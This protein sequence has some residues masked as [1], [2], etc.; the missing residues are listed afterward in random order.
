MKQ[1]GAA[2]YM[3]LSLA[4]KVLR[5]WHS[6]E[7][8]T[9]FDLENT[10]DEARESKRPEFHLDSHAI[11]D[12]CWQRYQQRKWDVYLAVFDTGHACRQ[13][14]ELVNGMDISKLIRQRD[15]EMEPEGRTCFAKLPISS[16]GVPNFK[17]LSVSTLP[18]ALGKLLQGELGS[19]CAE[20]FE[21]AVEDLRHQLASSWSCLEEP[22]FTADY[23]QQLVAIVRQWAG[24]PVT[25]TSPAWIDITGKPEKKA[26]SSHEAPPPGKSDTDDA[27]EEN[28]PVP[29]ELPILNSFYFHD[30]VFAQTSLQRQQ[31]PNPLETYLRSEAVPKLDLESPAGEAHIRNSLDPQNFNAGRWPSSPHLLQSL[32]QQF[33]M[34][35][36]LALPIGGI[37]SVNGPPGTGKTTLLRDLI[38]DLIIQR[39]T[40]MSKLHKAADGV[41]HQTAA[42][43]FGNGTQHTIP[44]LIPALTGYEIVVCSTNNGAVEN[45]S[46]ELPQQE[47]L[48]EPYRTSLQ[49]FQPVATK[50]AGTQKNLAWKTPAKP[51]WG[52]ISAALGNSA[53]RKR[54]GDIFGYRAIQPDQKPA[55]QFL[56]KIKVNMDSWEAEG[57]MSFWRFRE[58][59][60]KSAPNFYQAKQ[61][62][63]HAKQQYETYLESLSQL[64][65]QWLEILQLWES[66]SRDLISLPPLNADEESR[67]LLSE[68]DLQIHALANRQMQQEQ[69]LGPRWLRWLFKWLRQAEYRQWLTTKHQA[70]QIKALHAALRLL[71][72]LQEKCGPVQLCDGKPLDS[73]RNQEKT[74]WQGSA[75]NQRRSELFIAAMELHQAFVLEATSTTTLFAMN[76]LLSKRISS[77]PAIALWQWF[78]LLTPV[79]SSTFASVRRQFRGVD[80]GSL[81]WLVVDEAGQ[82]VPQAAVGA[83][84]RSQRTVVVGDPLQIEPVVTMPSKLVDK[85]GEY[86]LQDQARHY[87]VNLQSVQTLA[88]RA[89]GYGVR[90]PHQEDQFIGIPLV[91]HR[92][93]DNPMFE[94]AN[95]IAYRNRMKHGKPGKISPHPILGLSDW[96]SVPG[97][98][99]ESKYVAEQGERVFAALIKLYLAEVA[100]GKNTLPDV[101][102]IT[103]FREVKNGL[104]RLLLD[105]KQWQ[106][107]LSKHNLPPPSKLS[108]WRNNI[109]TVHT[110]Q[111][112]EADIVL[113]VLGCDQTRMGAVAWAAS[114]PNLLNVALTRAKKHCYII[115]DKTLWSGQRYFDVAAA[116]LAKA[117]TQVPVAANVSG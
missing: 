50:Y 10:I 60:G 74:F 39:A 14:A 42:I 26:A 90:H 15:E 105:K 98:A 31:A 37:M 106:Q 111:G 72:R 112:K 46:L 79:V 75:Y 71:Q 11:L 55:E 59:A 78:F 68:L 96:W 4:D 64:R 28:L 63:K 70:T 54:F 117:A 30:L 103:P 77:G 102:V 100:Q 23:L 108:D 43:V 22:E 115:G 69:T 33:A 67:V 12:N 16:D 99:T 19:L 34:N 97:H 53:N 44:L 1:Q 17:N 83:I 57:A 48:A 45:L 86:W 116:K 21:Q 29:D 25:L 94:I 2:E 87:A 95:T 32:M 27:N 92:R 104:L 62:F 91:V 24:D 38:A 18:W 113:F 56:S 8:F 6:I 76:S 88:D 81:G 51:V 107:R 109:G 5:Y 61:R 47:A 40:A 101:Y 80:A 93:C 20:S 85:L 52:L 58:T 110:F 82:A 41:S 84:L 114:Q 65:R 35:K 3:A 49:Y 9:H 36:L 13:V 7:F 89:H 73:A 66:I